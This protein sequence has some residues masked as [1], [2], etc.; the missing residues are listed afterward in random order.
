[1]PVQFSNFSKKRGRAFLHGSD[2]PEHERY[3]KRRKLNPRNERVLVNGITDPTQEMA[4]VTGSAYPFKDLY[5]NGNAR[6][7][8]K[9][10]DTVPGLLTDQDK[11]FDIR[12]GDPVFTFLSSLRS[13][14]TDHPKVFT[15][16]NGFPH[17]RYGTSDDF[18]DDIQLIGFSMS[19][20][21]FT[22]HGTD[23]VPM[24]V[25]I[26]SSLTTPNN[27]KKDLLSADLVAYKIAYFNKKSSDPKYNSVDINWVKSNSGDVKTTRIYP[28]LTKVTP[29]YYKDIYRHIYCKLIL[30]TEERDE[31]KSFFPTAARLG[32]VSTGRTS[33]QMSQFTPTERLAISKYN[34]IVSTSLNVIISLIQ[35][36]ILDGAGQR[37]IGIITGTR[38]RQTNMAD[39][40]NAISQF[41]GF[42]KLPRN[43]TDIEKRTKKNVIMSIIEGCFSQYLPTRSKGIWL[44]KMKVSGIP[45]NIIK[46]L[47]QTASI[48]Q[49][50]MIRGM[51][52][53]QRKIIGK[54][55]KGGKRG[56]PVDIDARVTLM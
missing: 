36:G 39:L 45:Q 2:V 51:M 20:Y 16:I 53:R 29:D 9:V 28:Q 31:R 38:T 55:I 13:V 42:T 50:V 26:T 41:S 17:G 33:V 35:N 46:T 15:S 44:E 22:D 32:S 25:Y 11:I 43:A 40:I 37:Q 5:T 3:S 27:G 34:D 23:K 21:S 19:Q 30:N 49:D 7:T 14:G 52:N 8:G 47:E 56:Q 54:V 24:S 1:V 4:F 12:R 18:D 48:G 10:Q 6:L